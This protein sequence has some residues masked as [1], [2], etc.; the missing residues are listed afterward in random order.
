MLAFTQPPQCATIGKEFHFLSRLWL[1]QPAVTQL[2]RLL[3]DR[4]G[5]RGEM[6]VDALEIADNIEVIFALVSIYLRLPSRR[7]A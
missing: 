7:R 3:Q 6:A 5:N 4:V 1:A 2:A